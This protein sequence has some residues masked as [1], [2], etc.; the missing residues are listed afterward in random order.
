MSFD[1]SEHTLC[2]NCKHRTIGGWRSKFGPNYCKA[3]P[4]AYVDFVGG[5]AYPK[6]CKSINDGHYKYFEAKK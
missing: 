5:I 2:V 1:F 3:A 6:K 4:P